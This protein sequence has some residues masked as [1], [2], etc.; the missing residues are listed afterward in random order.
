[1]SDVLASF[2]ELK[3]IGPA[4]EAK[5]HEAGVYTWAALA[6]VVTA[7]GNVRSSN[8]DT[9]R[10]LSAQ[11]AERASAAGGATAP[12]LPSG[13]RSEAFIV[14]MSLDTD[15]LPTRST[16]THV[17]TQ[18][19]QPWAGWSPDEVIR[20]IEAQATPAVTPPPV[21]T[22]RTTAPAPTRATTS[23]RDHVVTLDVGN[24]IGGRRRSIDLV[25]STTE[26]APG[27]EF[28]YRATLAGR[29]YGQAS[30]TGPAWSNL[31]TRNGRGQPPERLPL[32]FE[33]V[34]LPAGIQRLR[35]ELMLRLQSPTR[36]APTLELE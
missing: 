12:P 8:G 3:G 23:S 32:L 2:R 21:P 20:F 33:A 30:S 4:T 36:R 15:G 10:D 6:E 25:V 34:E 22:V 5:L 19:E 1:M 29:P 17:R 28:E 31:A 14:R 13:E 27:A 26:V 18:T 24:V 9:L 11:I 16:V 7:L 35:V